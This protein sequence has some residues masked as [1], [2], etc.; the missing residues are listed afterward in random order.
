MAQ[1]LVLS[2]VRGVDTHGL[3]RLPQY[4]ERVSKGMVNVKPNLTPEYKTPVCAALDGDNGF[5]FVV[6]TKGM[7][8]AIESA[9]T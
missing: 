6:A 4:L 1:C 2:D 7:N 5:G 8:V 9:K 3:A